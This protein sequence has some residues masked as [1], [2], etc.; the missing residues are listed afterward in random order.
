MVDIATP[1][2]PDMA[3]ACSMICAGATPHCNANRLCVACLM[4]S[5]CPMGQ[6]C[7]TTGP[8]SICVPGCVDDS[9][10]GAGQKCC[11]G[12][13]IDVAKDP[14]NCG[15][16]GKA[17]GSQNSSATCAGGVCMPGQCHPGWGDCN[18][19]PMDGCETNLRSDAANCTACGMKCDL[20]N[21]IVG[22][23]DADMPPCYIKACNF[24]WDDCN[25]DPKDGCETSVLS[26]VRNCG[27]CGGQFSCVAPPN[28]QAQCVNAACQLKQCNPG[29]TD[30]D[31]NA[32]NGCE[33][34]TGIDVNNCGGCG[35]KCAQ[36]LVCINSACTCP[37][38]NIPNAKTK[39]VNNQCT[40]D[41]CSPGFAD[42]DGTTAVGSNG[43]EVNIAID[44]K[45]CAGCGN[46][47]P[48]QNPHCNMA[49]CGQ[50]PPY[51]SVC[52]QDKDKTGS[53]YVICAMDQTGGWITALNQGGLCTYAA[54]D[55][56]KKYNFTRIN[57]GRWGGTC[58]IIC[59][60]C[61]GS[62]CMKPSGMFVAGGAYTKFDGGGG[63]PQNGGNLSCTVH[64][65]CVP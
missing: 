63:N 39:C 10:C 64:W 45:N 13:C 62:T 9:R 5:H 30:C 26:D 1:A 11:D 56:C 16:C 25:A 38:C 53:T 20:K 23:S 44:S 8:S 52:S 31:G 55:I 34:N 65:E 41:S 51:P 6:I 50:I 21:A 35:Q 18:N 40:F 2:Q 61:D 19:D 17:C 15:A 48:M 24:G 49:V 3:G 29:F 46:V 59:G 60:Y 37:M 12:G 42:C 4:D 33:V 54:L 22:C 57:Q 7:K 32:K 47:C 58:G 28:A 27:G 14:R 43:C 36:G